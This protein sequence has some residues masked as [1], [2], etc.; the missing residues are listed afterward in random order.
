MV[1]RSFRKNQQWRTGASSK[2]EQHEKGSQLKS[3]HSQNLSAETGQK[4]TGFEVHRQLV[5]ASRDFAKMLDIDESNGEN[6]YGVQRYYSL[7]GKSPRIIEPP[8]HDREAGRN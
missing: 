5:A 8:L 7:R 2:G 4:C 1:R 6:D 3:H